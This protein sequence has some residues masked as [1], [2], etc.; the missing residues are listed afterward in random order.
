MKLMRQ[1]YTDSEPFYWVTESHLCYDSSVDSS[2]EDLQYIIDYMERRIVGGK[3]MVNS[4][5]QDEIEVRKIYEHHLDVTRQFVEKLK[6]AA[7]E[8]C[9]NQQAIAQQA[10]PEM[11]EVCC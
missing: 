9:G 3:R 6:K 2:N 8:S 11:A 5:P 7:A 1:T 4:L 10:K